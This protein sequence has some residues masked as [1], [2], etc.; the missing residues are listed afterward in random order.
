MVRGCRS[1]A[2]TLSWRASLFWAERL[3]LTH[4]PPLEPLLNVP[5]YWPTTLR[6]TPLTSIPDSWSHPKK[7][8]NP[9]AYERR[10]YP[11]RP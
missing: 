8:A 11:E 7:C 3:A 2:I 4:A 10:V 5:M 6:L 9:V 1:S